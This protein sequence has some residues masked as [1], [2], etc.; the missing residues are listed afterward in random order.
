M[1]EEPPYS[2]WGPRWGYRRGGR[3]PGELDD[4]AA[5]MATKAHQSRGYHAGIR[6]LKN[7]A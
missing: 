3:D 5:D 4:G 6:R 2:D 7:E 1:P